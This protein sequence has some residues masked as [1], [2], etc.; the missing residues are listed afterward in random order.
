MS[1]NLLM[2][3]AAPDLSELRD[4]LV[5]LEDTIIFAL[6]ERSQFKHNA[7]IYQT[8]KMNF[9]NGYKGSFLSW[10]LKEVEHV[11][12]KVRRYQSPDEYPF[13]D[14]LPDPVLPPLDYPPVLVDPKNININHEIFSVYV[15]TVV[16]GITTK[17]DDKNYGS[18]AT[19]DIECLQALSRRI[20][21]GKFVAESKFQ[22]PKTHDQ[23]VQL[24]K[25]QNR[26]EL[27]RLLTNQRVENLLLKRLKAKA[28]IYGQD[29]SAASL[30]ANGNINGGCSLLSAT[31][32]ANAGDERVKTRVDYDLVVS[33]YRDYVIPLTKEVEVEYLLHRLD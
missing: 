26:D 19:R 23:Y 21:Y 3:G 16:P 1:R 29:L 27:M 24:I 33:L 17:G 13:T 7:D 11:H 4:T 32:S 15:D 12:A 31:A 14:D 28:I 18:S 20:H 8:G 5:R 10:F 25:E 9:N 22:D 30:D 2:L 6:I